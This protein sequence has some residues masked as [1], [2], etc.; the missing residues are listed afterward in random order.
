MSISE[1]ELV[2]NVNVWESVPIILI[3]KVDHLVVEL[4]YNLRN[5]GAVTVEVEFKYLWRD[6]VVRFF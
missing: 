5:T 1:R 2:R 4:G 3:N 6:S